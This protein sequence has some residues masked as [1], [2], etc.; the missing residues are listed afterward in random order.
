MRGTDG[1]DQSYEDIQTAYEKAPE[2]LDVIQAMSEMM[3][4]T[5]RAEDA[6]R[7]VKLG[8]DQAE[9]IQEKAQLY[10]LLSEIHIRSQD[11]EGALAVLERG[12]SRSST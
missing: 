9:S 4:E 12:E 11:I 8:L 7:L 2:D 1:V 5:D 6:K 10:Q 3:L